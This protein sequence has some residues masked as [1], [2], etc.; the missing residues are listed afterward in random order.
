MYINFGGNFRI[1]RCISNI[2]LLKLILCT[3]PP[4]IGLNVIINI[5][6]HLLTLMHL[7]TFMC[8]LRLRNY[9]FLILTN[10]TNQI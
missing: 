4:G 2:I 8:F 1:L 7:L 5:Q 6:F 3:W 10:V 9:L